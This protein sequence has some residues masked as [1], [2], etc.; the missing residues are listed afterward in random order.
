MHAP[1]RSAAGVGR[2]Q[3]YLEIRMGRRATATAMASELAVHVEA[4]ARRLLGEPNQRLSSQTELRYGTHGSLSVDLIKGT[5]FSHEDGEGGGV[6]DLIRRETGLANGAAF[7]WLRKELGIRF[8][9][10]P[11][12]RADF[13]SRIVKTYDYLDQTRAVRF[14]VVR[15]ADPKDFRQRRPDGKG[16]WHW[17]I[18]GVRR[19]LYGLPE[20]IASDPAEPVL[21]AE[22]ERDA[23]RLTPSASS[24]PAAP[25]GRRS[26]RRSRTRFSKAGTSSSCPISTTRA[27]ST[28][29]R[30][31][32]R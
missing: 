30:W 32:P 17:N 20:L 12:K 8:D 5:W 18:G 14:Q 7:D 23:D 16:G 19:I 25:A 28:S 2:T 27:A 9:S 31:S 10:E 22:G 15:L 29:G 21:I 3:A 13:Q 24:P 6:L 1:D 26:G 4:V 11:R